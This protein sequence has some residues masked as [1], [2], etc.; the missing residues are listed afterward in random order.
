V[1]ASLILSFLVLVLHQCPSTLRRSSPDAWQHNS[2]DA[3][4]SHALTKYAFATFLSGNGPPITNTSA[5][6]DEEDPDN[7][8]YFMG[9]RHL[10]YSLL[11][12]P[13][14][15]SA[16]HIPVIVLVT[17]SVTM[18]KRRCLEA[19]GATVI[20]ADAIP[21][22]SWITP[23]SDRFKD[24]AT[25]LALFS[26]TGYDKICFIDADQLVVAPL[27]GVF[28]DAATGLTQT[29][30]HQDALREDEPALPQ[31]YIFASRPDRLGPGDTIPPPER[32]Y[33]NAGFYVFRPST[34]LLDYYM[35]LLQLE[36]RFDGQ[37]AEQ[38]LFNYAHRR[39]GN[40]PWRSLHWTWNVNWPSA[41]DYHAGA[42]SLHG[43][44]WG[45][46]ETHDPELWHIWKDRYDDLK[47]YHRDKKAS[48]A[49]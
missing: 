1:G 27:D 43:K 31:D 34:Q 4:P 3:Q 5:I 17:S 37:F 21:L 7:D 28:E 41:K 29:Q 24:A 45:S 8:G 2:L 14:T 36:D 49:G 32:D 6:E 33:L 40:M 16:A 26:Q 46:R 44:Y 25:K 30:H 13:S 20:V 38:D 18:A 11:H 48:E 47:A 9:A 22:P 39:E 19:E 12:N 15:K 35:G 42:R 10:T 23:G